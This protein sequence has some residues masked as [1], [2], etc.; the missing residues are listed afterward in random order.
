MKQNLK[1]G[2]ILYRRKNLVEHAGAYL[3]D[4][5]VIHNSPDGNVMVC[6]VEH[7]AE[8]KEVKVI[9]SGLSTL[10][11]RQFQERAKRKLSESKRY[12]LFSFNCEQLVYEIISGV[13]SSPQV[14]GAVLGGL[15]CT[16]LAKT[17]D[18]KHAIWFGLAGAIA[19]C[20]FVNSQRNY[21]LVLTK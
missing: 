16:M 21:D 5:Q 19:G 13:A 2:D 15:A 8:G 12:N 14:K 4:D 18:S 9:S 17:A 7:F 1:I 6:S 3:G 10:Q 20:A 11:A